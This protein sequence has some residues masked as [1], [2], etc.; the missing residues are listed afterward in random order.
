MMGLSGRLTDSVAAFERFVSE[1]P[2]G[3][4]FA[5]EQ[6]VQ[7]QAR[8]VTLAAEYKAITRELEEEHRRFTADVAPLTAKLERARAQLKAAEDAVVECTAGYQG[9]NWALDSRLST[10]RGTLEQTAPERI[11]A[12]AAALRAEV[13]D[14]HEKLEQRTTSH[15]DGHESEASNWPSVEARQRALMALANDIR[16]LA[17]EALTPDALEQRLTARYAA[18][19]AI[20][21]LK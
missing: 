13:R 11:A 10:C 2:I 21:A 20:K 9:R 6:A 7:A 5:A 14:C 3:K 8:R 15:W 12:F 17:L 4:Q 19:P 18:L 16:E 1:S